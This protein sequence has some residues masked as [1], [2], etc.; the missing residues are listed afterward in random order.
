MIQVINKS[1]LEADCK[2]IG[3]QC[4]C[5]TTHAAGIAKVI[6]DKYPHSD[7][8]R[9][10]K[11]IY[12]SVLHNKTLGQSDQGTIDILGNGKNE[13]FVIN[14]YVQRYP[15]KPK[16]VNDTSLQSIMDKKHDR[17]IW[18]KI[19]LNQISKIE[20]IESVVFP[21]GIGCKLAGGDWECVLPIIESFAEKIEKEQGALT[22]L[23]RYGV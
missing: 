23:Y 5:T 18:L 13:R 19:C 8:Y 9:K 11:N 3:H 15:G 22:Y 2:Y 17:L 12:E 6:F 16:P 7:T 21:E 14:M 10:R 4:N 20:N 1:L